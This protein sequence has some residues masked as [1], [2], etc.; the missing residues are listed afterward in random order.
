[1]PRFHF[2]APLALAALS[3]Q[4]GGTLRILTEDG[5]GVISDLAP[6]RYHLEVRHPRAAKL[7]REVEV[8]EG[9]EATQVV[10]VTLKPSHHIRCAPDSGGADY[11]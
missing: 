6:G 5:A 3:A 4:A 9:A 8:A 2:R 7:A 11:K 10:R 1:M